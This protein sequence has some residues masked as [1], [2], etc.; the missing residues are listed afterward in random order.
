MAVG[1]A[2]QP[3]HLC[4]V[5]LTGLGDVVNGLPAVNAIRDGCRGLR[6][7]WIAEPMP[8]SMLEGHPSI[9]KVVVYHRSEGL[10][11]IRRLRKDLRAEPAIDATIN[12]N[13]YFK[14][15]WP[16]L[17]SRAPRRIGFDRD[18]SFD[19]VWLTANEHLPPAPRAHTADMLLE[20]ASYLGADVSR[21][22][23]RI[24][25]SDDELAAQE[26]F[27]ARFAGAPVVTIV[28]ASSSHKKDWVAQRW[29]E[30]ADALSGD[31]GFRVVI[32]GGPGDRDNRMAREIEHAAREPVTVALT[33]SVRWMSSILARAALVI[34]PDTGPLHVARALDV[35]VIGIYGHTN[36]WRVGP[37]RAFSDL[38]VD[39]YTQ[40]A[41][42]PAERTPRWKVM[43]TITA[44]EVLEK[45]EIAVQRYGAAS[46]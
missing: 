20:F 24:H 39:H 5:L 16:T 22:E 17:L 45:V 34:A 42:D 26:K 29:A 35:P 3:K 9:D 27:Y 18:R 7:T 1:N 19:G 32:T 13:I 44:S 15:V 43:P 2:G 40:G 36:P 25:L 33:G 11:G 41:P 6:I 37:W 38:W 8:A 12:M 30:V 28:P 31:F 14:S 21:P 23:Y 46:R 4:V 10:G